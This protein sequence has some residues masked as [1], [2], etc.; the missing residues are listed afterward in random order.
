MSNIELDLAN[1]SLTNGL[2]AEASAGTGKTYSVAALLVRELA[3]NE[4]LRISEVLVTTYTRTAAAELRDRIRGAAINICDQLRN[5]KAKDDDVVAQ[6]LIN[7][8]QHDIAAMIQR[9]ERALVEFDS[10]TISTIHSVCTKI[11]H[12]AGVSLGNV[13]EDDITSRVVAEVVNDA[14]ISRSVVGLSV[15]RI[16]PKNMAE[17][18]IKLL[19]DPFTEPWYDPVQNPFDDGQPIS[20]S[21]QEFLAEYLQMIQECKLRVQDATI[22]H[23]SFDDLLKRAHDVVT[24]SS[25]GALLEDIRSRFKLAIVDEAQDTDKLQWAFFDALFPR[26]QVDRSLIAVGDPKQAIFGFRGAD[27][28]AFV[29][30]GDPAKKRTL[31]TNHRSDNPVLELLNSALDGAMFGDG[32]PYIHVKANDKNG[33]ARF[34]PGGS[35][36]FVNVGEL[37]NQIRLDTP[38]A[39]IVHE[40]L[41]LG[42][43]KIDGVERDVDPRDIC[44]LVRTKATGRAIER[45]LKQ[46]KIPAVSNG[47]ESVMKGAMAGHVRS[48]F[49]LMERITD[50]GRSRRAASSPF[51]GLSLRH[52]EDISDAELQQ[53]QN[54]I[55]QLRT[56]LHSTG[57]AALA[58]A[59]SSDDQFMT[60]LTKGLSG[61]RNTTDFAHLMEVLHGASEGKPCSPTRILEIFMSLIDT[62]ETS[63]LVSR[64]VESDVDAVQ[65]MTIHSAKGLQFPCVVVADLWKSPS[66]TRG[67]P[68]FYNQ[69]QRV[70]DIIHGL[71]SPT[72]TSRAA[73]K[74]A[75]K[76]A[77][78]DE[79]SRLMYVALT[80]TM[81][82]LSVLVTEDPK[83]LLLS[84]I[85][86]MPAKRDIARVSGLKN[87]QPKIARPDA[88][89][90][91][92]A[93]A[94]ATV[95]QSY[96]RT[97]FSGLMDIRTM[98][99]RRDYFDLSGH[100]NDEFGN[101]PKSN[102]RV[103]GPEL[104]DDLKAFT[105]P[106][107]PS[108]KNIG[109]QIHDIFEIVDT[110][111]RPLRDEVRRA[112][113][114]KATSS[115]LRGYHQP[116]TTVLTRA[117][118]TPFGGAFGDVCFADIDPKDRLAE[119][120]FEMTVA[121]SQANIL[122]SD[123]G[124][125]LLSVLSSTDVLR[126]YARLLTDSSFD[127]KIA[128]IINGS[129]DAL[130][131]LP[132][133]TPIQPLLAI[134]DYKSNKLHR[135]ADTA[136]I[137]SYSPRH[138]QAKMEEAHYIL[139][140]LIYGTSIYRML[141]WRLPQAN[142]DA[143]IKGIA[144]GFI[145][146][147]VGPDT[148]T[149]ENGHRYGVFTWQAPSGLWSAL[150]DLF[151]GN[152]PTQ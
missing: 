127:I 122:A 87:Y 75:V 109:N 2:V 107:L 40:L 28:R 74:A 25:R 50:V 88:K 150:S 52:E 121:L 142:H 93:T 46:F 113:Q 130:L 54:R 47:T 18:V 34:S 89:K 11:L 35:V 128:G 149:G 14:I 39:Q 61:E 4:D 58:G 62:D 43:L 79:L 99:Q 92:C 133:S 119:M 101:A 27:V 78:V 135:D 126:D 136:P 125:V 17:V 116:L 96:R 67:A 146:G 104:R 110:S 59:I 19:A 84:M 56:V 131:R 9:L 143:C 6:Y 108:S 144:Y 102:A 138:V 65:I 71:S 80:R 20:K 103:A 36:E 82:H 63:E 105:I 30:R 70:V 21:D 152:K 44:V 41:T 115:Q 141:R 147:M 124:R 91:I 86:H 26:A 123:I 64:R 22:N 77:G 53:V 100:G 3:T 29:R 51:F 137:A 148:P 10:A 114:Q 81:H 32:I 112:V 111:V 8:F 83:S 69:D 12:L 72:E 90:F 49:E 7:T 68:V 23:P 117:L 1:Q 55:S 57:V 5:N 145:R 139:Q 37:K 132:G 76:S 42:K 15:S 33:A 120:D 60:Q 85:P 97:S 31:T 24:D 129:L 118:E 45:K 38:T 94:P 13:G 106:S 98:S 16:N 95:T 66:N 134:T 140:A 73:A 48:M 151:A